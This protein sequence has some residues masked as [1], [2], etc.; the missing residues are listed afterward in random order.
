MARENEGLA[1]ALTI[2]IAIDGLACWLVAGVDIALVVVVVIT[3]VSFVT[4]AT[5]R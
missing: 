1:H 5:L 2:A 4:S 3:F